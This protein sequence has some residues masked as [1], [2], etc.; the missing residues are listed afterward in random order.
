MELIRRRRKPRVDLIPLV[1]MMCYLIFFFMIFTSFRTNTSGMPLELPRA[2][3]P[4]ELASDIVMVGIDKA[5]GIFFGDK[6][7]ALEDVPSKV[8]E[9]LALDPEELFAIMADK[10]VTYERLIQVVDRIREGGGVHLA[11]AVERKTAGSPG[12]ND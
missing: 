8:K 3:T 5:G 2:A 9:A 10:T 7:V 11:L 4:K 6:Q 12:G 1:D